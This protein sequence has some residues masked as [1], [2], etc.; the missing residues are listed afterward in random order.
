MGM[1]RMLALCGWVVALGPVAGGAGRDQWTQFRGPASGVIADDPA[2]PDTWSAEENVA[3]KTPIPGRG[4]SSPIVWDDHIFVTSVISSEAAPRPGLDIIEDGK[5]ASYKEG[6]RAPI[7]KAAHRWMLYDI[8]FKTGKV[9]WE[10]ELRSGEPL[11]AK[12]PKNSYASETPVTDGQ[13]VYVYNGDLGLHAFDFRGKL[14]WTTRVQPPNSLPAENPAVAAGRIDF[15][16]AASPVLHRDRLFVVDDH[17]PSRPWFLAAYATGTGKELWRVTG[18]RFAPGGPTWATP[19]VWQH[20]GRTEVIVLAGGAVRA[21]DLSGQPLW[22]V[23]GLGSNSTPTPFAA[24]GLLYVSAGYPADATRPVWAIKPGGSGDITPK[25]GE[26]ASAFVVWSQPKLAS[27]MPSA[28]VY[29]KYLYTL[30]S[31]GFLQC[32]DALTGERVYGRKRIDPATSGFTASPWAYNGKLF[33]LSED[34]DTYVIEPGP[35]FKVLAKNSFGEMALATPAVLRGNLI[36][37]TASGVYRV[38][39]RGGGRP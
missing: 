14:L 28:L 5:G 31:Q 17:E 27:Y 30:E 20:S 36:F 10:R 25:D 15:G 8:D 11:A 16:T 4:W 22:H 38:T 21:Y 9:R 6:M 32:N 12:H 3:W 18:E 24:N 7:L 34:G 29:G 39:R 1:G 33:A 26:S 19:F 13:R 2:L 37:R 23:R 35:D